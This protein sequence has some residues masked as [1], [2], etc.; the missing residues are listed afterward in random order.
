MLV[1]L[2]CSLSAATFKS[3]FALGDIRKFTCSVF[4]SFMIFSSVCI[5]TVYQPQPQASVFPFRRSINSATNGTSRYQITPHSAYRHRDAIHC[6]SRI[7]ASGLTIDQYAQYTPSTE[8]HVQNAANGSHRQRRC[9][10]TDADHS[11]VANVVNPIARL[12]P[13]SQSR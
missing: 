5:A 4:V 7:M 8:S 10:S 12:T 2:R 3:R 11:A 9:H 1:A 13:I 6:P